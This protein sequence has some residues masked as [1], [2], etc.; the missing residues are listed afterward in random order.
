MNNNSLAMTQ[1]NSSAITYADPAA[2]AAAEGAKARIQA[3]YI[4]AMQRPRSYDQSRIKNT[5][6]LFPP[7]LRREGRVQQARRR[8]TPDCGAVNPLR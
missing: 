6:S 2:V 4:M 5:G 7:V 8:R 3:A 1:N